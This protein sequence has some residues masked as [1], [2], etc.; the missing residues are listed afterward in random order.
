MAQLLV[1]NLDEGLVKRLRLRAAEHG[2][3]AEEEHRRILISALT[4][5][6]R[7]TCNFKDHL[8]GLSEAASTIEFDRPRGVSK[9]PAF[10]E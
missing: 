10:D 4:D 2:I 6:G 9:R 1:R 7:A 8:M 5:D 3:S